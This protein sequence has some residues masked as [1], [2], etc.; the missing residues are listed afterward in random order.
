MPIENAMVLEILFGFVHIRFGRRLVVRDAFWQIP[1]CLPRTK[2]FPLGKRLSRA[3][4][5]LKLLLLTIKSDR[6]DRKNGQINL[7]ARHRNSSSLEVL[8]VD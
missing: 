1:C 3:I 5:Q 8:H 7:L 2:N 4:N 6:R